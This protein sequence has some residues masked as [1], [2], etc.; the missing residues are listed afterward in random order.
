M[1]IA[2]AGFGIEGHSNYSYF[3]ALENNEITIVDE[4]PAEK[5]ENLPEGAQLLT[6]E[7]VFNKLNNFDLV[8]RTAGLSPHKI[9]T[10]GKIWS[11]T[12]E[13]F[14][15]C[16]APIIGV[17]GSKGKGTT[18]S[19]ISEILKA[20]G[21]KVWLVGN[22]G[23]P[24]LD[25]LAEIKPSDIVVYELSS[26][27]LWDIEYSPQVAVV[28]YIE[29]EH[30]DVHTSMED[31]VAAKANITARQKP[32]EHI[33][34]NSN[35]SYSS[36][37]AASSPAVSIAYPSESAAH[38]KNDSFYYGKML[39]CPLKALKIIGAHNQQNALAA[40]DAAWQFTQNTAAIFAGLNNFKGLPH[41]L[42]FVAEKNG[43]R[44][45]DDSIAT[46]PS[47]AIAA[48]RSFP[49]ETPKVIILGGSFKGSD[50]TELALELTKHQVQAI[51]IGDEAERLKQ[52]CDAAGFKN[53]E[54]LQN[55]KAEEFTN[56]AASL[57]QPGSVVLLSPAAASF[58]LF[59][60]YAHRGEAFIS[61]VN[62]LEG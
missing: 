11:A 48:L 60:N 15:K 19:L 13:F 41:R 29:Q 10:N 40:I 52:A 12:N 4:R 6:G 2:I 24:A 5:L 34:Y 21:H 30:L 38:I 18:A 49:A 56:C 27:Q 22:I 61:A 28:L 3:S 62:N 26:F 50:F 39:I 45:Y 43:V 37:I 57:A 35:N 44:Y 32:N 31:Y 7:G 46:T 16:P 42:A 54:I 59:K 20:A 14:S 55:T 33:I 8:V 36:K 9:R 53:Y 1:R 23:L 58:G 17:T 25:V 47:S 51:L